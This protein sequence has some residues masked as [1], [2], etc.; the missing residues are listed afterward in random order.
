MPC[1]VFVYFLASGTSFNI[2]IILSGSIALQLGGFREG[3][4]EAQYLYALA[5][6]CDSVLVCREA[7]FVVIPL[8]RSS[9]Y[10]GYAAQRLV[11]VSRVSSCGV[12][13]CIR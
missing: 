4:C 9:C 12:P 3:T 1:E 13:F 6:C 8:P 5:T 7:C 10:F 11:V 2:D